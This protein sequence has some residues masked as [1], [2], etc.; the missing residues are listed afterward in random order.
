[1]LNFYF[2]LWTFTLEEIAIDLMKHFFKYLTQGLSQE[3]LVFPMIQAHGT[4][5]EIVSMFDLKSK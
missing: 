5:R 2:Q 1:M 3:Q 4:R